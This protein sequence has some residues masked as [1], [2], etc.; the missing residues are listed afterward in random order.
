M[1]QFAPLLPFKIDPTNGRK[2]PETSRFIDWLSSGN[3]LK[4]ERVP[5]TR[6]HIAIWSRT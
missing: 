2:A 1:R 4:Y 6:R 3:P 5:E